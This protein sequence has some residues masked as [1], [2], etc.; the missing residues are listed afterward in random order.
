MN[1]LFEAGLRDAGESALADRIEVS[2][3]A[4][5]ARSGFHEYYDPLTGDGLGGTTFSWTAA[6]WLWKQAAA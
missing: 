4:L 3:L 5:F 2:S 6:S 1:L